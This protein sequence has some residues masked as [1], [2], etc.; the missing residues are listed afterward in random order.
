MENTPCNLSGIYSL[1]PAMQAIHAPSGFGHYYQDVW[2]NTKFSS[3]SGINTI[4]INP[5]SVFNTSV[6]FSGV[7]I[8]EHSLSASLVCLP[9]VAVVEEENCGSLIF[10]QTCSSAHIITVGA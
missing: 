9:G 10:S 7:F 6:S 8:T 2:G 3:I 5:R 1:R 4:G